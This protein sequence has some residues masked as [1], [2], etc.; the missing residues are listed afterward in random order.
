MTL[1]QA[2]LHVDASAPGGGDGLT[3]FSAFDD[4]QEAFDFAAAEPAVQEIWV[5]EGTYVP[6]ASRTDAFVPAAGVAVYGGFGGFEF[7]RSHRDIEAHPTI[8]SGLLPGGQRTYHV[9]DASGL[10]STTMLDGFIIEQGFA[11]GGAGD[12]RDRGAAML[13]MHSNMRVTQCMFRDNQTGANRFGGALF[14]DGDSSPRFTRCTFVNNSVGNGGR[15]G[16]VDARGFGNSRFTNCLFVGNAANGN[17]SFGGALATG[18]TGTITLTNCIFTGNAAGTGGA[19][20]ADNSGPVRVINSTLYANDA[21]VSGGGLAN[22]DGD[23]TVRNVILWRNTDS[24]GITEAAQLAIVGSPIDTSI[25]FSL[26]DGLTT[27]TSPGNI[28][29]DP[30]FADADGADGIP[31]TLDDNLRLVIPSPCID[32]AN[33]TTV[34]TD[35][36]DLDDDGDTVESIPLDLDDRPRFEDDPGTIDTGIGP[37]PVA[38]M[39]AFEFDPG[40]RL[41][42]STDFIV[43]PENDSVAFTV[44]LNLPPAGPVTVTVVRDSGDTDLSVISGASINFNAGNYST[45]ALVEIAAADDP[46]FANGQANFRVSGPGLT[47]VIVLAQEEDDEILPSHVRVVDD[48]APPGG[49]GFAWSVAYDRLQDALADAAASGGAITEIWVASGIYTPSVASPGASF[50]LVDDVAVRGGFLGIETTAEERDPDANPT[51]LS[52]SLTGASARHVIVAA[53]VGPGCELDGFIIQRG[54][55]DGVGAV[56]TDRG[57]GLLCLDASPVVRNCRFESN[58]AVGHGGAVAVE[59]GSP[60]FVFCDFIANAAPIGGGVATSEDAAARFFNCRFLGNYAMATTVDNGRGGG[61]WAGGQSN[62]VNTFFSGNSGQSGG[63]IFVPVGAG[64][65][66]SNLT[67][68]GNRASIS[69]GGLLVADGGLATVENSI[70]WGN[71]DAGGPDESAQVEAGFGM[72]SVVRSCVAGLADFSV[73][74]NTG[75]DPRL[76]DADGPDDIFGTADDDARLGPGSP[77]LDTAR[78]GALPVDDTFD[79][80]GDGDLTERLPLDLAARDRFVNDVLVE[81]TGSGTPTWTDMGAVERVVGDSGSEWADD[82]GGDWADAANW[83][84]TVPGPTDS[85][86]LWR[87]AT[88]AIDFPMSSTVGQFRTIAGDVRLVL[89]GMTLN[90]GDAVRVGGEVMLR[91]DHGEL[92]SVRGVIGGEDGAGRVRLEGGSSGWTLSETLTI[93][94]GDIRLGGNGLAAAGG[95]DILSAGR[96]TGAGDITGTVR[97]AGIITPR[98]SGIGTIRIDGD[99]ELVREG[100]LSTLEIDVDA[101]PHDRIIVQGDA[102]LGGLLHL[103]QSDGAPGIGAEFDLVAASALAG[104]PDAVV[105]AGAGDNARYRVDVGA[106]EVIAT[107]ESHAD[108]LALTD[109]T[110]FSVIGTP[111]DMT[112]ADFDA[113]GDLDIALAIP[114]LASSNPG[115][116]VYVENRGHEDGVWQGLVSRAPVFVGIDPRGLTSADLDDD[117]GLDLVSADTAS[118][119]LS[120]LSF[121]GEGAFT[122]S[123]TLTGPFAAPLDVVATDMTG[124]DRADL[125]VLASTVADA[126]ALDPGGNGVLLIYQNLGGTPAQF[127]LL[128][129]RITSARSTALAVVDLNQDDAPDV[130]VGARA[131]GHLEIFEN[132]GGTGFLAAPIAVPLPHDPA[133]LV[134]TG[135]ADDGR[136]DILSLGGTPDDPSLVWVLDRGAFEFIAA[137]LVTLRDAPLAGAAADLD[138]DGDADVVLALARPSATQSSIE[139]W[140]NDGRP[141]MPRSVTRAAWEAV[142]APAVRVV[143]GDFDGDGRPDIV[144]FQDQSVAIGESL[145][146]SVLVNAV[147]PQ[148]PTD[149][150]GD[151]VVDFDDLNVILTNWGMS[152]PSWQGGDVDGTG[153]IDFADLNALL[154]SWDQACPS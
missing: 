51:I 56:M 121:D 3:W 65:D 138:E 100:E 116:I 73:P 5:S 95:T 152:G 75:Q 33:N 27:L 115:R 145:P 60:A 62:C 146:A 22:A 28:D 82:T 93:T 134:M 144:T 84:P 102:Q 63:G 21:G 143:T 9:V 42:V 20:Y 31:G 85:V 55:A 132:A 153:T 70:L 105:M 68:T 133:A 114:A 52:G 135:L 140:R 112:A 29:A 99:L 47:D 7:L 129:T 11:N 79:L 89:G 119:A 58:I 45:P 61:M 136:T 1:G 32:S 64:F 4:L 90:V 41:L 128:D 18:A 19:V 92:V 101:G 15:G 86:I 123:A 141:E 54:L 80:D 149:V 88:Y 39:G 113:D 97:S 108:R 14:I 139:V 49:N 83:R 126:A 69:G 74:S 76:V 110:F 35:L 71:I 26:I 127:T 50:D 24:S 98:G 124:D 104:A 53:T 10:T 106:S 6:G 120:I 12:L 130:I 38:D 36:I 150:T 67:V 2:V 17:S 151:G 148:C 30:L 142:G 8:L 125:V 111:T 13:L 87:D 72:A 94:A 78:V 48:D 77:C 23:L 66:A 109:P 154:A 46:D 91:I 107:V 103:R 122:L 25:T 137:G 16:A 57:A 44:S 43:V 40:Q 81:D 96:I 131:P 59:G 117:P 34:G 37:A 147:L 118:D